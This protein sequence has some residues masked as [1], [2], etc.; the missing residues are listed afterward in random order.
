MR[1][2]VAMNNENNVY[3]DESIVRKLVH[4]LAHSFATDEIRKFEDTMRFGEVSPAAPPIHRPDICI[5]YNNGSKRRDPPR[6]ILLI[7]DTRRIFSSYSVGSCY[8]I[9]KFR[10]N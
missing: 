6:V 5:N 8:V 1:A 10:A 7:A 2:A 4:V 3:E 9:R